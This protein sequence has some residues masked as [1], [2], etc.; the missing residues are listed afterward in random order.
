LRSSIIPGQGKNGSKLG[1]IKAWIVIRLKTWVRLI[2]NIITFKN[3]RRFVLKKYAKENGFPIES[4][5]TSNF[6]P[7][8]SH[9][10]M[11]IITMTMPELEFPHVPYKN[12]RYLGPM[13]FEDRDKNHVNSKISKQLDKIFEVKSKT[14]KKLIYCSIGSFVDGDPKF[15]QRLI[16]ALSSESEFL[17]VLSLGGKVPATALI[18]EAKNI[19]IFDWVPQLKVM[20]QADCSINHGGINSI[21]ECIHFSVPML[22]YSGKKFDQNGCA[23]RMAY[24]GIAIAGDKD[25]DDE[26]AIKANIHRLLSETSF[27]EKMFQTHQIYQQHRGKKFSSFLLE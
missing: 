11:P 20:E 4:L 15:L 7:L 2:L 18:S 10:A 23:A 6:P 5:I 14:G 13:V 22:I 26:L 9:T 19:H 21:N 27:S 1:I 16:N 3:Y 25:R 8:F 12:L 17:L 24:H